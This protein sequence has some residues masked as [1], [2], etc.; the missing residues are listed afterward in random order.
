M[1]SILNTL[2]DERIQDILTIMLLNPESEENFF[3]HPVRIEGHTLFPS[4]NY[5]SSIAPFFTVLALWVGALLSVSLLSVRSERAKQ[6]ELLR[7]GYLARLTFFLIIG[8][9]QASLVIWG[10]YAFFGVHML[11]PEMVWLSALLIITLFQVI[12]FSLV[13]LLGNAGKVLAILILLLQLSAGSGTFPVELTNDFFIAVHPFLP[14]TYAINLIREY[15]FGVIPGVAL[16]QAFI[17]VL[18]L[19]SVLLISLLILPRLAPIAYKVNART[20]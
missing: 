3:K 14:F 1:Q 16:F 12:A 19:V 11:H 6:K 9:V 5:G 20:E 15:S 4:P 10:N 13:S 18:M 8:W 17:L 7:R 2:S